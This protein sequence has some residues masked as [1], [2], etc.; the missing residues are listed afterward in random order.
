MREVQPI[1]IISLV[2]GNGNPHKQSQNSQYTH[3]GPGVGG[4]A[5]RPL[6][7]HVGRVAPLATT[8]CIS[9]KRGRSFWLNKSI[10]YST[11]CTI[12]FLV[13][14]KSYNFGMKRISSAKTEWR[15]ATRKST[16]LWRDAQS[17]GQTSPRA[18]GIRREPCGGR[19]SHGL[20]RSPVRNL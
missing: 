2:P 6:G 5:V 19:S 15:S 3:P 18:H 16:N 10:H 17:K 4:E 1:L 8:R 14:R 13:V 12:P 7:R 20:A 9:C 11:H